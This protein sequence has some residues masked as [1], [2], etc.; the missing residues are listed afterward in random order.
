MAMT[1]PTRNWLLGVGGTLVAAAL[2][3]LGSVT[4]SRL[5]GVEQNSRAILLLE[6]RVQGDLTGLRSDIDRAVAESAAINVQVRRMEIAVGKLEVLV[7]R[8]ESR[9]NR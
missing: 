6:Q 2:I 4:I 5:A 1:E 8:M 9:S 7:D 3:A